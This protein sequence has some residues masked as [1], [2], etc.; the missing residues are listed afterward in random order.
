MG[1]TLYWRRKQELDAAKFKAASEDV[2]FIFEE[3]RSIGI[4]MSGPK[5]SGSARADSEKIAFN[6][7]TECGHLR[8][9]LGHTYPSDKAEGIDVK[10]N[11]VVGPHYAG[12]LVGARACGGDCSGESFVIERVY[13]PGD[14][15]T[16]TGDGMYRQ[17][18]TT[19]YKPYDLAVAAALI[20]LK[21]YLGG[22]ICVDS[23]D[24]RITHMLDA[25]ALCEKLFT[26]TSPFKLEPEEHSPVHAEING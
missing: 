19:E 10:E 24:G 1:Y 14:W 15:E 25:S 21:H 22:E 13:V 11:T 20:R 6:G 16:E 4:P 3:L 5:G 23:D 9:R 17:H 26:K 7:T 12:A 18:C 2:K 8:R